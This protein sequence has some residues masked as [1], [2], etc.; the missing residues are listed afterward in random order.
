MKEQI[1]ELR[2]QIDG[3]SQL[4][5]EL[6]PI[7]DIHTRNG[8]K[9]NSKEIEKAYDSLILA[10]AWLGKVLEELGGAVKQGEHLVGEDTISYK[11]VEGVAINWFNNGINTWKRMQYEPKT[12]EEKVEWLMQTV[13]SAVITNV[14]VLKEQLSDSTFNIFNEK[15]KAIKAAIASTNV[16]NHL[17]EAR[18]WLGFELGRI[19]DND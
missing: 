11:L 19:R 17:C 13:E 2:I 6:K 18:F 8:K 4:T 1:K 5:K 16:Y 9:T 10:K 3:L 12:H 15:Q 14:L 7:F